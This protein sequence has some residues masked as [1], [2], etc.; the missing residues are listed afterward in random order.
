MT[1]QQRIKL[2]VAI[3]TGQLD[4]ADLLPDVLKIQ[5][6]RPPEIQTRPNWF[7]T[8]ADQREQRRKARRKKED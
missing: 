5:H 3:L 4:E 6:Q 7:P 8:E 1:P 2:A